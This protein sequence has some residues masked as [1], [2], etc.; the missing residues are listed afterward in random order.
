MRGGRDSHVQ[1]HRQ[2]VSNHHGSVLQAKAE[3]SKLV[4]HGENQIHSNARCNELRSI[5]RS[6]DGFLPFGQPNN[7]GIAKWDT[8]KLK[9]L[10][11]E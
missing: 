5:G 11:F 4:A 10:I 1:H 2:V 7:R 3:H 9:E 8:D 6:F